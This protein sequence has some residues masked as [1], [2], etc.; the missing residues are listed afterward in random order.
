MWRPVHDRC[1]LEKE[2][3]GMPSVDRENGTTRT[4]EMSE[5]QITRLRERIG[6]MSDAELLRFGLTTKYKC[7]QELRPVDPFRPEALVT[8][9]N[10]AR[11]EWL[12][13]NPRLPLSTSF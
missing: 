9:L 6:K 7:S 10:E 13:R 3:N 1:W 5:S 11:A 4:T 8:Q 2:V 12:S